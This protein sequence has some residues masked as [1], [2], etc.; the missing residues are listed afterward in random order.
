MHSQKCK[1]LLRDR[2][3]GL[4]QV[5][6][7][8]GLQSYRLKLPPGCRHHPVLHFDLLS[9]ASNLT[10]LRHQPV[11]IEIDHNENAIDYISD[12]KVDH[13]PNSRGLYLQFLTHFVGY[14]VP[15]WMLLEQVDDCE[16]PSVFLTSDV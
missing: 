13:W 12:A 15:E 4:F 3:L 5:L 1:H 16:Q 6:E 8:V 11:Q 9:K 10:T 2:R 7:K 14:G